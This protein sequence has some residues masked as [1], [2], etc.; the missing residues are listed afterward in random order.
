MTALTKHTVCLC[1]L[2]WMK[3]R[4]RPERMAKSNCNIRRTV[5]ETAE[6]SASNVARNEAGTEEARN[7]AQN[8]ANLNNVAA[9]GAAAAP[10]G[11]E[12]VL[13]ILAQVLARLPAAAAPPV[14]PPVAEEVENV[15][16]DGGRHTLLGIRL[17]LRSGPDPKGKSSQTR[18]DVTKKWVGSFQVVSQRSRVLGQSKYSGLLGQTILPSLTSRG[19]FC[20]LSPD[21]KLVLTNLPVILLRMVKS[22]CNTRRTVNET[23]EGSASNVA[24]NEDGTEEAQNAAQNAANLNNAVAAGATTGAAGAADVAAAVPVGLEAILA[25]LAQVLARLPAAAAPP[26]RNYDTVAEL[27]EK[28]AEQEAGISEEAKVFGTVAHVHPERSRVLGQSKYSG[29]LGQTILPSLPS[30]GKFC[31]PCPDPKLVLTNLPVILLQMAKSNRNTRRTVNETA[32]GS[33]S[34]V[35]RNEAGTKEARNADQNAANLNNAAA[36][37]A[38][39][40][41]VGLEAVLAILAQ[42]LARLPA[43]AAP[44][45]APPVSE[46][47]ENVVPE[48]EEAH[49]VRNTSYLKHEGKNQKPVKAGSSSKPNATG[50]S[51]YSTC[52]KMHSGVCRA[53]TG[54]CHRCGRHYKNQC[55]KDAQS[56]GKRPC[57]GPQPV[58]NRQPIMP[59]VYTIGDESMDPSTSRPITANLNNAAAA[60][61]AAGAAAAPVGL[62]AVLAILAQVLARLPAAAAPPVA[63]PVAEEVENVVI[64]GEEAHV[65]RNPS[66]LKHAGKNQKPVKAGSSS[67]P[68]ATGRSTCSTCGKMHSGVCRAATGA[69]HRCG[70]MDHKV[71]DCPEEDLR[72]KSENKGAGERLCYNCGETGHYKNQCPKDAQSAGKRPSDGQ[73]G[74]PSCCGCTQSV[75]SRWTQARLVRSLVTAGAA[76]GAAAAPVGLEAV[77]AILAQVLARLPA[78]AA[79][80][81]HSGVCRAA[82]GACHR[83]GCKDHKVRDCPEEDLRPKSQNKG[84]GERVCYN[85]GETGHYKNQCPKDAQSAGKRPSDGPQPAAKRQAIM[86][87]VYTIGDESMDPSTSRPITVLAWSEQSVPSIDASGSD[88]APRAILAC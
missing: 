73:R 51:A 45:V 58:E 14:A 42:V 87:R 31:V 47:V 57:D 60:G 1:L 2:V 32:E 55:P 38:A 29:L 26:I 62:E 44:P 71:R 12:A 46:E 17:T 23:A 8:A 3:I 77:L 84:D 49:V 15:V 21:P 72:P 36:A 16:P 66:Y 5:N 67:K 18:T 76:A 25:I 80:P 63:P 35:A 39:A 10:V 82:T 88:H 78:A 50:R 69:C 81:M 33:A 4:T 30:R 52:G 85:C 19:K 70:R 48:G 54:A 83:C 61:A 27:V 74:R 65:V 20:V 75:M 6:G 22:N 53:A 7:A 64:E 68:N 24:R 43:A 79:P 56:A 59:R 13:A 40:A 41:P 37:G 28:A 34:N 11:L 9:A 86:P